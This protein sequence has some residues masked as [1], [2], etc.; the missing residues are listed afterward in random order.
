MFAAAASARV[1][2]IVTHF[3]RQ[4]RLW[5]GCFRPEPYVIMSWRGV[6]YVCRVERVL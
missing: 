4:G 5:R 3:E 6:G 2:V 1:F